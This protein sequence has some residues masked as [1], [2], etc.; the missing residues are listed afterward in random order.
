M[1]ELAEGEEPVVGRG[2]M[3]PFIKPQ[4]GEWHSPWSACMLE[5]T[6]EVVRKVLRYHKNDTEKRL[7]YIT[8]EMIN[9]PGYGHNAKFSLIDQNTAIAKYVRDVWADINQ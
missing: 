2:I 9:L 6:K 4:P 1:P 5:P 8:T 7:K 3:Y